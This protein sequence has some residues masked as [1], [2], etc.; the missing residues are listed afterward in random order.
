M[1]CKISAT[2]RLAGLV[3]PAVQLSCQLTHALACPA[4]RRLRIATRHRFD[5]RL[6]IPFQG[7]VLVN[8]S[9]SARAL[10][11][12]AHPG[13]GARLPPALAVGLQAVV[14]AMQNL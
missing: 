2:L 12:D 10:S 4:Q 11:P 13:P 6:Q 9:L 7:W 14:H 5:E 8:R 1:P 3:P